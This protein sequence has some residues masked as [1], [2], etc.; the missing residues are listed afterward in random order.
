MKP[1]QVGAEAGEQPE[2]ARLRTALAQ[3]QRRCRELLAQLTAQAA[4]SRSAHEAVK[5][6]LRLSG[7]HQHHTVTSWPTQAVALA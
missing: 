1:V 6:S 4:E 2:A 7:H 5:V 3:E